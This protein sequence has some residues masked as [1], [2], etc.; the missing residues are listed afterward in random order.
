MYIKETILEPTEKLAEKPWTTSLSLSSA[1]LLI[2]WLCTED[3]SLL[4]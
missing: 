2:Y 4:R 1:H 3:I